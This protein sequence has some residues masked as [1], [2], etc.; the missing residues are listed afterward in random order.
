DVRGDAGG[1]D[2]RGEV[3]DPQSALHPCGARGWRDVSDGSTNRWDVGVV[4]A[5][6]GSD[7]GVHGES[8]GLKRGLPGKEA[9]Q[10]EIAGD[11]ELAA[12]QAE[13]RQLRQRLPGIAA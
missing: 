4:F 2:F 12:E 1:A 3:G 7:N 6:E 8:R 13:A 5:S 11:A 9:A 10:V